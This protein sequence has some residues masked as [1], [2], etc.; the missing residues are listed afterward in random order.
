MTVAS[1]GEWHPGDLLDAG[2]LLGVRIGAWNHFGYAAPESGQ[3]AIPPLG[4]RSAAAVT[5]GYAAVEAIDQL[6]RQL[7]A[8]RQQ[9]TGELRANQ[10]AVMASSDAR[11][12]KAR[13]RRDGAR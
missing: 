2:E 9:L 5:A 8:L 11:L 7:Y 4:E 6:T 13:A 10:D 12:A 1:P 3:A